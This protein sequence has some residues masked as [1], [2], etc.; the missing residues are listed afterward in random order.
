MT[1]RTFTKFRGARHRRQRSL[2]QIIAK[3]LTTKSLEQYGAAR[4]G[5][6]RAGDAAGH[7]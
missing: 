1:K 5:N 6:G 4:E 3:R 2:Q 7:G